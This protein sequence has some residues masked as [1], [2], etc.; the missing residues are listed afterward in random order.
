[1][2]KLWI[3]AVP[4][5]KS[6]VIFNYTP[7]L[8]ARTAFFYLQ[9]IGHFCCDE[10]YF[11]RREGYKSFLLIYTVSGKGYARYRS[12]QYELKRG[13]VLIMDCYDFQEYYSDKDELWEI[14]WIHFNGSTS[15]EY[16]NTIYE[17]FGSVINAYDSPSI[18]A[19]LDEITT[20][21]K[22]GD[23]QLEAKV[24][25]LIMGML[26]ELLLAESQKNNECNV[27]MLNEYVQSAMD[28]VEN[29]FEHDISLADMASSA[30]C[31]VYHFTRVFKRATGY[32]PHEYLIKFRINKAKSLLKN[33]NE[34]IDDIACS[35]GF[36]STSN[37]IR[38]F[39]E[40]DDMTP[41]KYRRYWTG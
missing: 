22:E 21:V 24:S 1:M 8:I 16:F 32:S 12:R 37:F 5:T 10:G 39:K 35:V 27:K 31:S 41:L 13:Q 3:D 7:S 38:T 25:G 15:Y 36:Y 33:T 20:L 2:K 40:L 14:K 34:S 28:Y 26:T 19:H 9:S 6:E 4:R 18:P 30:C 23:L 17:K 11:T 29:N